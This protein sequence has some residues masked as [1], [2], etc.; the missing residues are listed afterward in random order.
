MNLLLELN[1][2]LIRL[3]PEFHEIIDYA[4]EMDRHIE[5]QWVRESDIL[6]ISFAN[7]VHSHVN[8]EMLDSWLPVPLETIEVGERASCLR[9]AIR[10]VG[11]VQ[12]TCVIIYN[13]FARAEEQRHEVALILVNDHNVRTLFQYE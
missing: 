3:V 2:S 12:S 11:L 7:T 5:V 13:L 1:S 9:I 6:H 4:A 10:F 8:P